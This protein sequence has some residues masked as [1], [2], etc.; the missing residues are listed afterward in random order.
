MNTTPLTELEFLT[1]YD[2]KIY[3]RPSVAV[4][5]VLLTVH[6]RKLKALLVKRGEHPDAGKWS[7]PGGF[8]GI[9]EPLDAAARRILA[10]KAHL[11]GQVFL[12]QLFTFGDPKRDPRA[13][14][15]SV[16]HLALVNHSRLLRALDASPDTTT[17]A[18]VE[19]SWPGESAGPALTSLDG[20]PISLAFDHKHILGAAVKRIRGKLNYAP[21][22]YQLLPREFTLRALQDVHE[23]ILNR[24]VN[25]DAF[26]RRILASDELRATGRLEE[27]VGHRPA[28]LYR[29]SSSAA[30]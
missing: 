13:R 12:E 9:D 22:G 10:A 19:V 20:K 28:E 7:L 26:R 14:V 18:D 11:N 21:I 2:P 27:E 24:P 25:K 4:D 3:S 6:E 30:V 17:L 1:S 8:V 29:F 23:T 16:A 15:I 5:L